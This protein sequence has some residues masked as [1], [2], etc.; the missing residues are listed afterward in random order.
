MEIKLFL[1]ENDLAAKSITSSK[2]LCSW[3]TS[4]DKVGVYPVQLLIGYQCDRTCSVCV[5]HS[6]KCTLQVDWGASKMLCKRICWE[7]LEGSV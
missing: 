2:G 1:D 3:T 4:C 5:M 6:N 7:I